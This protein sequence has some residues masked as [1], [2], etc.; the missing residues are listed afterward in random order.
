MEDLLDKSERLLEVIDGA[1]KSGDWKVD[2]ACDPTAAIESFRAELFSTYIHYITDSVTKS[3]EVLAER[4]ECARLAEADELIAT[5]IR[6]R[7]NHG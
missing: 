4:E 1:I 3:S 7:G 5:R 2:G 6:A